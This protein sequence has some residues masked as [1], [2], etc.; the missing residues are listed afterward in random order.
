MSLALDIDKV[1]A[2]LLADGWHAVAGESFMLDSYEYTWG[3]EV[4]HGGGN[5]GVC[6]IGF[7][8]R[9]ESDAIYAGPLTAIR[10]VQMEEAKK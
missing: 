7:W 5:S 2:V 6:A 3:E 4:V 1:K 10:A 9:E 8:F